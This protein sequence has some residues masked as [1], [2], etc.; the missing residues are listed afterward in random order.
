MDIPIHPCQRFVALY[1]VYL[2]AFGLGQFHTLSD[3]FTIYTGGPAANCPDP[4]TAIAIRC[5]AVSFFLIKELI[6]Q[7]RSCC[8]S[9]NEG[10]HGDAELIPQL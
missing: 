7:C 5:K 8:T 4:L 9:S 3:G 10:Q 1:R 6:H 2:I